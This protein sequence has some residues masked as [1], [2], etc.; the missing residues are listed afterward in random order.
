MSRTSIEVRAA[1][2]FAGDLQPSQLPDSAQVR[3]A[4][5][6]LL[7]RHGR[8]WCEARLAEEF[9]EH[10]E[11]AVPRMTWAVRTIRASYPTRRSPRL[12]QDGR[13]HHD[14]V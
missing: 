1:A 5:T 7:R 2:L 13:T 9:G 14:R 4:V 3:R 12:R 10:P 6:D 8:H 11:T